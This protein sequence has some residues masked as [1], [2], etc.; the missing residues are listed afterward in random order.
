M[1]GVMSFSGQQPEGQGK[2]PWI[3]ISYGEDRIAATKNNTHI[4]RF[5]GELSVHN[6]AYLITG[7]ADENGTPGIYLWE[8]YEGHQKAFKKILKAALDNEWTVHLG[9]QQVAEEDVNAWRQAF[10]PD[11]TDYPPDFGEAA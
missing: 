6:H 3:M 2:E 7:E 1:G 4:F 9:L 10:T 5:A 11:L 8:K